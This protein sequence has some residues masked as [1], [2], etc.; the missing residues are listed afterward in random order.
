MYITVMTMIATVLTIYF[1]F[2]EYKKGSMSTR[3]FKII[4]VCESAALL[5]LLY[6]LFT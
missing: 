6:L 5:G 4:C 3:N 1:S 2:D